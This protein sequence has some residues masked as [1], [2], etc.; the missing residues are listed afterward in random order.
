MNPCNKSHLVSANFQSLFSLLK[1]CIT[2][3]ISDMESC[4]QPGFISG[5][6]AI[7]KQYPILIACHCS[8]PPLIYSTRDICMKSSVCINKFSAFMRSRFCNFL[9]VVLVQRMRSVVL[10]SGRCCFSMFFLWS[11][12]C[13]AN[14]SHIRYL[15]CLWI[16]V[17]TF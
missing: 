16:W 7:R 6:T 10:C 2:V 11:M 8:N 9:F 13:I 17:T 14:V 12:N 1:T 4:Y 5:K 3:E 15:N